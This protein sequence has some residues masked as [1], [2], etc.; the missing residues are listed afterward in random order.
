ML[1]QID[2]HGGVPIYRQVI[3]QVRRQIMTGHLEVGDQ[4]ESVQSLAGRLKVNPMTISKAYSFLVQEGLAERRRGVGLFVAAVARDQS[5]QTKRRLLAEALQEAAALAVQM[6]IP[7]AEASDLFAQHLKSF[8][9]QKG[10]K[11]E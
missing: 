7:D 2:T 11:S 9:D 5:R 6:D 3:D 10:G 1:I 8:R 4:L